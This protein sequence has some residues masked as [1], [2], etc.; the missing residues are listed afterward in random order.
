M[1]TKKEEA[2]HKN[3]KKCQNPLPS[4]TRPIQIKFKTI[5]K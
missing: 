3:A 4:M 5:T 1:T 2:L